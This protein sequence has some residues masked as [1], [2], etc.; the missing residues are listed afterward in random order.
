MQSR[1]KSEPEWGPADPSDRKGTIYELRALEH[2]STVQ[3]AAFPTQTTML[4]P[5][6]ISDSNYTNGI[7]NMAFQMD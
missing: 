2:V 7:G 4:Y 1:V 5:K 6:Y 3:G